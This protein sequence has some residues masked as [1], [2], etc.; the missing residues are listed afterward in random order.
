[1]NRRHG[2]RPA[3]DPVETAIEAALCP[4]EFINHNASWSFVDDLEGPARA[5]ENIVKTDAARAVRLYET[6]L[7]GCY[8]KAEEIDDS[9]GN[10]GMFVDDL[11]GGLIK[12][13]QAAGADPDETARWLLARMDDDPYGFAYHIERDAV[14]VM[15]KA[16][17]AAFARQAR[18]RLED[19]EPRAKEKQREAQYARRRWGEVLRAIHAAQD[20]VAA[21]IALCEKTETTSQDCLA[22]ATLLGVKKPDEALSWIE[23]GVAL[24]EG[25]RMGQWPGTT[26]R[27]LKRELLVKAGRS[28][29]AR[30]DA[31]AA[32]QKHP[33]KHSYQDLMRSVPKAERARWHAKAMVTAA[34]ADLGSLIELWL[35]TEGSDR[36]VERLR[37]AKDAD[38]EALSHHTM[39]PAA[40]RLA[41]L[42][43]AVAAK[44]FRA[45]GMRILNAKKSKYYDAALSNFEDA[46]DCYERAG[47]QKE[48]QTVVAKVRATHRR[49]VGFMGGFERLVAGKRTGDEPSFLERAK[50]RWA[51]RGTS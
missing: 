44:V 6:Y 12:A 15:N 22:I 14:K 37:R 13:R 3:Q 19:Q 48:W 28:G 24:D 4:G 51:S 26:S 17:L 16:H 41:K 10:F 25:V 31:W 47:L 30:E 39:E 8:E 29:D 9:S 42:H 27:K 2:N 38:L 18:A 5:I 20:D 34:F 11:Y 45:L 32:F 46:K 49:R 50:S 7:A 1:M 33:S 21:Y 40:K 35:E 43:P 23:R 36:L